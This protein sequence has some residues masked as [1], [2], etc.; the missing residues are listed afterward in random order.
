M[1]KGTLYHLR[2]V[3]NRR[4]VSASAD[5]DYNACDDFFIAVVKCHI[6]TAA[7]QYFIMSAI[8]DIPSHPKLKDDTC[9]K[10]HEEKKDI[11][12]SVSKEVVL[13][14]GA[15]FISHDEDDDDDDE[16]E[17]HENDKGQC[18]ATELL[19]YGLLYM[20]FSDATREGDGLS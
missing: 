15:N 13:L 17:G 20:E 16:D 1:D 9:L 7:M 14:Y 2:N 11:L 4:N 8:S 6:V 5:V 19:S 3:I 10:S 18:Y 12:Q